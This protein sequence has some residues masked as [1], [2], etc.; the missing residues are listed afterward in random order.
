MT[1]QSTPYILT[2]PP[3]QSQ[4]KIDIDAALLERKVYLDTGVQLFSQN[5]ASAPGNSV[6]Y[7]EAGEEMEG[8][9]VTE[10]HEDTHTHTSGDVQESQE[11]S[12]QKDTGVKRHQIEGNAESIES[13]TLSTGVSSPTNSKIADEIEL[14]TDIVTEVE[15]TVFEGTNAAHDHTANL[16]DHIEPTG[17]EEGQAELQQY[18]NKDIPDIVEPKS[19]SQPA[20]FKSVNASETHTLAVENV[21]YNEAGEQATVTKIKVPQHD[22]VDA[23][24]AKPLH[25]TAIPPEATSIHKSL[26][27]DESIPASAESEKTT[28]KNMLTSKADRLQMLDEIEKEL[29]DDV[30][31]LHVERIDTSQI[32]RVKANITIQPAPKTIPE[33]I[34]TVL[35]RSEDKGAGDDSGPIFRLN[36]GGKNRIDTSDYMESQE[37]ETKDMIESTAKSV[38]TPAQTPGKPANQ[39]SAALSYTQNTPIQPLTLHITQEEH[40][41]P[42]P[43]PKL[44][45]KIEPAAAIYTTEKAKASNEG[46]LESTQLIEKAREIP[47][48]RSPPRVLPTARTKS[49]NKVIIPAVLPPKQ[50]AKC[51]SHL[52]AIQNTN[53]GLSNESLVR[54]FKFGVAYTSQTLKNDGIFANQTSGLTCFGLYRF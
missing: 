1:D 13:S 53:S 50:P 7:K 29:E 5:I 15:E 44:L 27:P 18:V 12:Q 35:D 41:V 43:S 52:E 23:Q 16:P 24:I 31:I 20:R 30:D 33:N 10:G 34:S 37:A 14:I 28:N 39:H 3:P 47:I 38:P 36:R 22:A 4:P 40:V 8:E 42:V 25:D 17:S 46:I 19:T 2:R 51:M 54:G 21:E 48:S 26:R 9:E 6:E 45:K 11:E 32:H 49:T